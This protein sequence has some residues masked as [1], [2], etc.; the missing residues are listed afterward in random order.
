MAAVHLE[1]VPPMDEGLETVHV[2]EAP[3][4][5]GT[6][7]EVQTFP[8]G[9]YPN[10]IREVDVTSASNVLDWFR[11]RFEDDNGNF[12][13]YSSPIQGGT[14]TLVAQIMDRVILRDPAVNPTI[15]GQE[16]E[17]T[18]SEY[19]GVEDPYSVDPSEGTPAILSGLTLLALARAYVLRLIST[20]ISGQK[21]TAGL[22]S[23]DA[24]SSTSTTSWAAI[25]R[26]IDLANKEL[27]RGYSRI[28]IM[29]EITVGG[30][31]RQLKSFD[32]SRA[33]IELA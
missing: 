2:E 11:I 6:F 22:V 4:S 10:Y 30:G 8:I 16:A 24:G 13:E 29:S 27:G 33:I 19:F 18:V 14:T 7:A 25:D 9:T 31:Y 21:W 26:M 12:T 5:T 15:A 28:G 1:F 3:A 32:V 23:M 17:A 20:T